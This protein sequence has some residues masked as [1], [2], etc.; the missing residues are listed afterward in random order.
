MRSKYKIGDL[1]T[2]SEFGRLVIDNNKNRVGLI[3]A[4]PFNMIYPM[5]NVPKSETFSYWAYNIMIGDELITDVPQDFLK[6]MSTNKEN[7]GDE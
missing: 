3:V 6:R 2:L 5:S 1:I 7:L 4:G